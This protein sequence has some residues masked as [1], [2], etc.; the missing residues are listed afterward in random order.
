MPSPI[1]W[2]FK[3]RGADTAQSQ[4]QELA[5]NTRIL[6]KDTVEYSKNLR[7]QARDAN[8]VIHADQYRTRIL[9]A[10]HP[11]MIQ[12]QRIVSALSSVFR[13]LTAGMMLYNMVQ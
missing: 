6:D 8:A 1:I 5:Q 3:I 13:S 4:L 12:T 7:S 2:D 9:M 10:Q 11:V